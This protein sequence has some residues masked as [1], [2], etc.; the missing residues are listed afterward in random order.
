MLAGI[1]DG[2]VAMCGMA[3]A[4]CGQSTYTNSLA[5]STTRDRSSVQRFELAISRWRQ[6]AGAQARRETAA[7]N[8]AARCDFGR[9]SAAVRR[10]NSQA[11]SI[12]DGHRRSIRPS[13]RLAKCA[14]LAHTNGL[15]IRNSACS[16]TVDCV[17]T[18]VDVFV[19]GPSNSARIR[20]P[21]EPL[22][23]QVDAA[24]LEG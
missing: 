19:S 15:F 8:A 16:G 11:S 24:M 12:A 5:V 23:H 10:R 18:S 21:L 3:V 4:S 9:R 20:M 13:S 14:A 22:R 17:R 6:S 2:V 7:R 1:H